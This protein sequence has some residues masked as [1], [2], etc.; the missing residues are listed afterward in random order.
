M[1]QCNICHAWAEHLIR[2]VHHS[3]VH[4][5]ALTL[6]Y[7]HYK[8][9]N[10]WELLSKNKNLFHNHKLALHL[11]HILNVTHITEIWWTLIEI[12]VPIAPLTSP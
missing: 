3:T 2:E 12:T 10:Q 9:Q 7:G 11:F 8:R 1:R 5:K 6:V 4:K